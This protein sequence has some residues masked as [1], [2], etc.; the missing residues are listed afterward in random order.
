M[1]ESLQEANADYYY[2]FKLSV[3]SGDGGS[4]TAGGEDINTAVHS[5]GSNKQ[6]R[7]SLSEPT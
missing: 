2:A 5:D 1:A 7:G 4:S 3:E 6:V